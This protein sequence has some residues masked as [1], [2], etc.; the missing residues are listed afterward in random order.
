MKN[1][2][3]QFWLLA[4]AGWINREQQDVSAYLRE[5]NRVC[6]EMLGDRRPRF[7]G[8]QRRRLASRHS[9]AG[10]SRRSNAS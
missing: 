2:I 7:N 4:L 8:G 10:R 3:L 6:R 5:E 9:P 1:F